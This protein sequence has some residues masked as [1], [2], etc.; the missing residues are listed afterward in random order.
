[1]LGILSLPEMV[2]EMLK[3]ALLGPGKS[4]SI[5]EQGINGH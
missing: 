4:L 1:M 2:F 3:S 5:A